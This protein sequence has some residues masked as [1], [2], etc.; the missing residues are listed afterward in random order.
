MLN[1]H[2]FQTKISDIQTL[3]FKI[4][5]LQLPAHYDIF[6]FVVYGYVIYVFVDLHSQWFGAV[7]FMVSNCYSSF[8]YYIFFKISCKFFVV[9]SPKFPHHIRIWISIFLCG[10]T[11]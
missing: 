5:T 3:H 2:P 1:I 6:L 7:M 11:F 10:V 8:I 9:V 4:Y